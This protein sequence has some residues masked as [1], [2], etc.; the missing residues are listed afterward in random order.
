MRTIATILTAMLGAALA[1]SAFGKTPKA[2][3]WERG[4]A[5]PESAIVKQ[6][7]INGRLKHAYVKPVAGVDE[8]LLSY[9]DKLGVCAVAGI[10]RFTSNSAYRS[11]V[12]DTVRKWAERVVSKFGKIDTN[13]DAWGDES[14][15][16]LKS[17][18]VTAATRH[19][20]HYYYS[21]RKEDLPEG[22]WAI[23]VSAEPDYVEVLFAF[24]NHRA[25]QAE[26]EGRAKD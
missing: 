14:K 3:G 12:P 26:Q 17:L 9:T 23:T 15:Y 8:V 22:Y 5:V 18:V 6:G 1:A 21:W 10:E 24:D 16:W 13:P 25:C 7:S 4:Q 2:L 19:N 11:K 20:P